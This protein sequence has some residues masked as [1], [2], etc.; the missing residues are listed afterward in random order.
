M[1]ST[2]DFIV[3]ITFLKNATSDSEMDLLINREAVDRMEKGE[4]LKLSSEDRT[5]LGASQNK[6][7]SQCSTPNVEVTEISEKSFPKKIQKFFSAF[8]KRQVTAIEDEIQP[9]NLV[10]RTCTCLTHC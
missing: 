3:L 8:K 5:G 7:S 9:R 6:I 10:V 4:V 1:R 2:L